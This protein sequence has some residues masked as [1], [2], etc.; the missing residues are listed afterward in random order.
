MLAGEDSKTA[1]QQLDNLL[2]D[3]KIDS[4]LLKKLEMECAI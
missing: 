1:V 4:K 2:E 3:A